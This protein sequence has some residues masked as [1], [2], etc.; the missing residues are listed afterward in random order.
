MVPK[1]FLNVMGYSGESKETNSTL[2]EISSSAKN[3][4]FCRSS[5]ARK[6]SSDSLEDSAKSSF[7]V[8]ISRE[9]KSSNE[10]LWL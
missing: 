10:M 3:E 4:L 9:K 1:L 6:I 5:L 2:S 7:R 8:A